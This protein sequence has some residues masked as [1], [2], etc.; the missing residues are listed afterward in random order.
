MQ[1]YR[2]W[3][4]GQRGLRFSD[5]A[6][7]WRWSTT[8][9]S[10]F[11]RSIWDFHQI[12]SRTQFEAVLSDERMPGAEWFKGAEV[13]YVREVFRHVEAA[14]A[15]GVPAIV[16]EDELGRVRE[17]SWVELRRRSVSLALTMREAGVVRGDRVAAYLPNIP[18]AVIA[19]LACASLGAIWTICSPDIGAPAVLDRFRQISPKVLIVIDG[20]HYAGKALDRSV[21]ISEM[22]QALPSVETLYV[23]ESGLGQIDIPGAS[24]FEG[25]LVRD[26]AEVAAFEPE[27]LPFDHPLW[28]L[29]S[30]GTTGLPKAIVHGHGGI[31]VTTYAGRL[32][33]D[34]GASY[35]PDTFGER[36]HWYSATGWVMWNQQVGALLFGTTIC[37]FDGA[38]SGATQRHD[39]G[40]LWAF[41]ARQRVT[42]FGAGAA[43]YSA[44]RNSRSRHDGL[45]V[46]GRGAGVG[47]GAICRH[48]GRRD[49]VVQH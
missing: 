3:L 18:E 25:A 37:L 48:Q 33:F 4:E 26:D 5:Y 39:W 40:T 1:L 17:V 41:A 22:R 30:S 43:F 47:F 34:L 27:W 9:L 32:H 46:A 31:I 20:V 8:E 28:I 29:Y 49:V 24:S 35:E 12:E 6:A 38:P 42:W 2:D 44:C 21:A 19:L 10:A 15:M 14:Q 7:M 23:V 45:T 16:A 11:W 36:F 13:N